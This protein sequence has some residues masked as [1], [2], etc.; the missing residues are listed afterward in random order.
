MDQPRT[1][2]FDFDDTLYDSVRL[3]LEFNRNNFGGTA[4]YDDIGAGNFYEYLGITEEEETNR[5]NL[6]Y[7]DPKFWD[8]APHPETAK[9]LIHL[10][11]GYRIV[12][13]TARSQAWQHQVTSWVEKHLPNI[14]E[15]IIFADSDEF[16][17]EK[18]VF[19]CGKKNISHL[20]DD[21]IGQI[22]SCLECTDPK[23]GIIVFDRPWN[24]MIPLSVPRISSVGAVLERE[25]L[26]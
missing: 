16:K 13:L 1:I 7:S 23:V 17:N 15:E 25:L 8:G 4:T 18:K 11:K 24:R 2:A 5:W 21:N 3:F 20:V 22:T 19:I 12:I 26:K 14:F 9:T 6:F 10:K